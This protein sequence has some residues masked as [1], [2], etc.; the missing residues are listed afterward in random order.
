MIPSRCVFKGPV[1]EWQFQEQT[2]VPWFPGPGHGPEPHSNT[3]LKGRLTWRPWGPLS[4]N[5]LGQGWSK[6]E[7][8]YSESQPT[9][10]SQ[11]LVKKGLLGAYTALGA[12]RKLPVMSLQSFSR[13]YWGVKEDDEESI[14][15]TVWSVQMRR[16]TGE[17][18]TGDSG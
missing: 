15:N 2:R 14:V 8:L 17:S 1:R 13:G 18:F 4:G 10:E 3:D 9:D 7:Q 6:T 12:L 16:V 5:L 11:V